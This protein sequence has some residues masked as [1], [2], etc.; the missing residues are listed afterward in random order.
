MNKNI[1]HTPIQ[2]V[3]KFNRFFLRHYV[4]ISFVMIL[5]Y[6]FAAHPVHAKQILDIDITF[7]IESEL[8]GDEAVDAN[9]VNTET[10]QGV[11]TLTGSVN[12]LLAKER[13]EKIAENIVGVRAVI[14][15]IDVKPRL[16][17]NDSELQKAIQDALLLDPA[18]DAYEI[19]VMV[20][21]GVVTLVGTVDSWQERWLCE[22]VSKRVPGVIAV[23]NEITAIHKSDRPDREIED[24]IKAM[25]KND[26]RVDGKLIMVKVENGKVTLTGAVGSLAEKNRA[27]M[28]AYVAG[29]RQVSNEELEAV[30]WARDKMRRLDATVLRTNEQIKKAVKDAFRY[31]PRVYSFNPEVM[32]NNGKVILTGVVDNLK[33]KRAAEQDAR[34]VLGV[35]QVRNYLKVRPEN[36]PADDVLKIRVFLALLAN[37]WVDHFNIEI[38]PIDGWVYLAGRATTSFAKKEAERVAEGVMGVTRVI[39]HITFADGWSWKAD[40]EIREDVKSELFWS[41]F[42]DEDQV[43]V[44]VFD[45]VVTLNGNVGTWSER[46]SA[47]DNA[48]EGGAKKV[49]N[50]LTVTHRIYGPYDNT[51]LH[52][53][54]LR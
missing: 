35:W 4:L 10:R 12:H 40:Q 21:K 38:S 36:V 39:N 41:P 15:R 23:K 27:T 34:N 20:H 3:M 1:A 43:N 52:S 49:I 6:L 18:T 16:F 14:N 5:W 47:E 42:V 17:S 29:V 24:E 32:V 13:A 26:I 31:D 53:P 50:N 46:K 45:G 11:V 9:H 2:A 30:W 48:Y 37:P 25:L 22:T 44:T 28:D 54:Y 51:L 19:A 33:A 8:M 7:A